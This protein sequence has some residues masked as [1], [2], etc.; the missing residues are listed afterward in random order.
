MPKFI[1]PDLTQK[2][3]LSFLKENSDKQYSV[4]SKQFITVKWLTIF[5]ISLVFIS[6]FI[7]MKE[8]IYPSKT[9]K[10]TE[11]LFLIQ[12]INSSNTIVISQLSNRLLD[13]ENQVQT[14][15]KQIE[16]NNKTLQINLN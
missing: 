15:E 1:D 3:I 13:L 9:N 6:T 5:S 4:A 2:E 14:L 16:E 11:Q 12:E 10:L 7:G 8:Y